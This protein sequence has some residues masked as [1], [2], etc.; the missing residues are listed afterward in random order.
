MNNDFLAFRQVV[1]HII[2]SQ[3][4]TYLVVTQKRQQADRSEAV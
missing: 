3:S 2:E 1:S 4:N